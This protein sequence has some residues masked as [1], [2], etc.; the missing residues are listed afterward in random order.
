MSRVGGGVR[1]VAEGRES[2]RGHGV[3]GV[4]RR[5]GNGSVYVS[6]RG[7]VS[8]AVAVGHVGVREVRHVG[9]GGVAEAVVV[10]VSVSVGV[11]V[12]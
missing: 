11:G 2:M 5:V 8:V 6:V 9:V 12:G 1:G 7:V 10:A 3:R 4:V